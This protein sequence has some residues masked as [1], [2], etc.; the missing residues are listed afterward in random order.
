MT[1]RPDTWQQFRVTGHSPIPHVL[2]LATMWVLCLT[3][4]ALGQDAPAPSEETPEQVRIGVSSA[5][6][7]ESRT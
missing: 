5:F 6:D 4:S 7:V 3:G 2:A 1:K